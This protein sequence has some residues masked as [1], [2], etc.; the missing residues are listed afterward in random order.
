MQLPMEWILGLNLRGSLEMHEMIVGGVHFKTDD[1]FH[2]TRFSIRTRLSRI[3]KNNWMKS[4]VRRAQRKK[5]RRSR[6]EIQ[7]NIRCHL[8]FSPD[9]VDIYWRSDAVSIPFHVNFS[10][11]DVSCTTFCLHQLFL[12]AFCYQL[13]KRKLLSFKA[14]SQRPNS[15]IWIGMNCFDQ[16]HHAVSS[17]TFGHVG[18]SLFSWR[19]NYW[20]LN[21][22][23]WYD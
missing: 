14:W 10:I 16:D 4:N 8:L 2:Q 12:L 19:K 11:T 17:M 18:V 6:L 7:W 5:K 9:F 13:L 1:A 22:T 15:L 21:W 23:L 3:L 20:I